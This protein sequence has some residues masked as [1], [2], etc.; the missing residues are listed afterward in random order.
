MII[1][2]F[3]KVIVDSLDSPKSHAGMADLKIIEK[4]HARKTEARVHDQYDL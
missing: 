1:K 3:F 4:S 2:R